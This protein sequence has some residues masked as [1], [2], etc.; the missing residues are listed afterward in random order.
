[1]TAPQFVPAGPNFVSL[2]TSASCWD[3]DSECDI[4]FAHP[5]AGRALWLAYVRG[6]C[7]NY[8][9]HGVERALD[10]DALR[11]G[12]DTTIFAA[13]VNDAGGGGRGPA[14]Q[15]TRQHPAPSTT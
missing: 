10:M 3:P 9:K 13:C 2:Q 15:G 8:R 6:A 1:M 14:G 4:V 11:D 7:H 12:A 5:A